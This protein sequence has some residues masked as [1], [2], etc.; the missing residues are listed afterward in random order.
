VP[1][2]I[3]ACQSD[4]NAD[5]RVAG[6]RF[7]RDH[8]G[9]KR[10]QSLLLILARCRKQGLQ[11]KRRAA[12]HVTS[13]NIASC[14]SSTCSANAGKEK[15]GK[16]TFLGRPPHPSPRPTPPSCRCYPRRSRASGSLSP[17]ARS[18]LAAMSDPW[19]SSRR[20]CCGWV[21]GRG[22]VQRPSS[23]QAVHNQARGVQLHAHLSQN[24]NRTQGN[25]LRKYGRRGK[26]KDH[27]FRL[28]Q[29]L[30]ELQWDSANVSARPLRLAYAGHVTGSRDESP[31]PCPY[32]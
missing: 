31:M 20:P 13:P 16:L 29:D 10:S 18:S 21:A 1:V 6:P 2:R 8:S 7:V 24:P 28:S 4:S 27:V 3:T 12:A 25:K 11:S 26:P 15:T 9:K 22:G 17:A 5:R 32:S 23:L 14:A 30:Q 19:R